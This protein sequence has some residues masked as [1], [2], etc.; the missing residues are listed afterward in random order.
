MRLHIGGTIA[1]ILAVA[2]AACSPPAAKDGTGAEAPAA[3]PAAS[4]TSAD[5]PTPKIGKWK[6]TMNIPGARGPQSVEVCYSQKM[7]DELKAM[8]GKIPNSTCS[9]PAVNRTA[10]VYLVNLSCETMGKKSNVSM[11]YEGDFNS[12]YTTTMTMTEDPP[13]PEGTTTTTTTAEF[14]GPC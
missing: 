7:I 9:E 2:L 14:V 5:L 10:G 1:I 8:A 3:A 13:S 6:M 11:R 4:L 12:R